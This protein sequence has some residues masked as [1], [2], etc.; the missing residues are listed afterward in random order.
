M[1]LL[2]VGSTIDA[3]GLD[4]L[5]TIH[6]ALGALS[7]AGAMA[8]LVVDAWHHADPEQEETLS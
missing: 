8:W 5:V 3:F 4:G 7:V 6:V 1:G 2:A